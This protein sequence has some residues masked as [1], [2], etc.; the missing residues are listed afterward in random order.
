MSCLPTFDLSSLFPRLA[1]IFLLAIGIG[2]VGCSGASQSQ[3]DAPNLTVNEMTNRLEQQGLRL[4]PIRSL[5]P[6]F[7]QD[8]LLVSTDR[9]DR[10]RI[11]EFQNA[12]SASMEVSR[13]SSSAGSA[14]YYYQNGNIMAVHLGNDPEVGDALEAVLG[15]KRR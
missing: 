4:S 15:S 14:P 13:K 1:P 7:A 2:L 5:S 10:I 6:G 9:G 11:F 8:G 3:E 12:A